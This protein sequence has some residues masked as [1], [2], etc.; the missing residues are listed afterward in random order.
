MST[1]DPICSK[2]GLVP[3]ECDKE[4]TLRAFDSIFHVAAPTQ[5]EKPFVAVPLSG[6]VCIFIGERNEKSYNR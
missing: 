4:N 3:C 1:G 5:K 2:H 6:K